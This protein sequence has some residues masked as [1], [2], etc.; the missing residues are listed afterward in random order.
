MGYAR[1]QVMQGEW[2][3]RVVASVASEV[4]T[5]LTAAGSTQA[6]AL[7][8]PGDLNIF[9]TVGASTGGILLDRDVGDGIHV[10]NGGANAL[11]IYPP[12]GQQINAAAVNVAVSVPA[13][14]A[15]TFY[16]VTATRWVG[17]VSA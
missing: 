6:T 11:S 15:A 8:L 12:T 7:A 14:K 2:P 5:G 16:R 10:V 1:T 9:G 13:G 17:V 3:G 4:F